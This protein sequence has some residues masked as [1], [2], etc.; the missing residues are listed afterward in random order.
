[1]ADVNE[2]MEMLQ[3]AADA[4]NLDGMARYGMSTEKRLGVKVPQI[5]QIAREVGRDHQ[6]AL[7]LWDT[8]IAE[9]RIVA[10]MV[11][12]PELVTED[13]MDKW[14]TDF[15]SWDVC[16][17][18]CMNLFEKT[19]LSWG[20]IRAWHSREPE[21]E[22]RAAYALVA[23]LAWHDKNAPDGKFIELIPLIEEAA[24]DERNFVKKAVSW[25]L[26]NIGKRS[27]GLNRVA[28]A[29]ARGLIKSDDKTS[30]WIGKDTIRDIT[31]PAAQR[32]LSRMEE[33]KG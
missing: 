1:M 4:E 16:D 33:Q 25:A 6:L 8:G 22:R 10:S 17:Q 5:R 31:S 27:S 3:S 15:N 19:P 29:T 21:F 23:C 28:L 9:A 7:D 2:V 26:R 32:R 12:D 11:A 13:Q 24:V 30:R 20:R 18:V 14:I